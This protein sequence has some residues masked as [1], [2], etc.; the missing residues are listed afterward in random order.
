[1]ITVFDKEN[2]SVNRSVIIRKVHLDHIFPFIIKLRIENFKTL[3][4]AQFLPF[5]QYPRLPEE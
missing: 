2:E 4:R 3:N 1:M 5:Q